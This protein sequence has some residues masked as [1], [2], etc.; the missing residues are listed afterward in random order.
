MTRVS[1][2]PN[3]PAKWCSRAGRESLRSC[4]AT[5]SDQYDATADGKLRPGDQRDFTGFG[6]HA[7]RRGQDGGA[8]TDSTP[9]G[10]CF[11][12]RA[13][14]DGFVACKDIVRATEMYSGRGR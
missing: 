14:G 2:S 11:F 10:L 6:R 12:W 7:R 5:T 8:K 13:D 4:F 9:A 1:P 3:R